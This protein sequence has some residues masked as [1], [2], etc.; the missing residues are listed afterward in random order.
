MTAQNVSRSNG[1]KSAAMNSD[2]TASDGGHDNTIDF[3]HP[4]LL[5]TIIM[6]DFFPRFPYFLCLE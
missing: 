4:S 5:Q 1:V 3:P 6:F 2:S